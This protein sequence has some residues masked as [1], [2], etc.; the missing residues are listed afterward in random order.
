MISLLYFDLFLFRF[1]VIFLIEFLHLGFGIPINWRM[2][3]VK[4]Q[5]PKTQQKPKQRREMM[6]TFDSVHDGHDGHST[7][8]CVQ[9]LMM[10]DDVALCSDKVTTFCH[11]I[12][13]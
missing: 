1:G 7:A 13:T 4:R 11:E 3:K 9:G 5:V 10:C 12:Q 6:H 2:R 8:D